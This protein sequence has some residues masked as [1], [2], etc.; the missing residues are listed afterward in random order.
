MYAE[1][2]GSTSFQSSSLFLKELT[3]EASTT[4]AGSLFLEPLHNDLL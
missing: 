4:V 3:E 2:Y 1:A